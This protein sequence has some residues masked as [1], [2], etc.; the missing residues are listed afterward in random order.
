MLP[1]LVFLKHDTKNYLILYEKRVILNE[2]W[3]QWHWTKLHLNVDNYVWHA[4]YIK[5]LCTSTVI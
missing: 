5:L 4:K 1:L 3:F 2:R